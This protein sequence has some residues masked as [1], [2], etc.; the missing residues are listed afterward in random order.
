MDFS[1]LQWLI[2]MSKIFALLIDLL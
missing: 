2:G 1:P